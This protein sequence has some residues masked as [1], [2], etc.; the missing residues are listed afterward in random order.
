MHIAQ[1]CV[2][3]SVLRMR[4]TEGIRPVEFC[5]NFMMQNATDMEI[6]VLTP[7]TCVTVEVKHDDKL[8]EDYMAYFQVYS[9]LFILLLF[10]YVIRI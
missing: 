4:T 3:D 9:I 2:F 6:A 10:I 1:P 7:D 5:G 8:N